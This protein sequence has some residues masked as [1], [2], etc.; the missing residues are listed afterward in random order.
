MFALVLYGCSTASDTTTSSSSSNSNGAVDSASN[1]SDTFTMDEVAQHTSSDDCWMVIN[2][3]VYDVS[4]YV[5]NHPGGNDILKGCGKEATD[6]F[7]TQG[8]EGSHSSTADFQLE[9]LQIGTLQ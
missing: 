6:M 3:N 2:G 1:S 7:N 8:G 9:S 5:R 4:S